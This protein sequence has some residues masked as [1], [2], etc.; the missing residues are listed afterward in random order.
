MVVAT[1]VL[2]SCQPTETVQIQLPLKTSEFGLA[3]ESDFLLIRYEDLLA[4]PRSELESVCQFLEID[5]DSAMLTPNSVAEN[6]GDTRGRRNIVTDNT[7]KYRRRMNDNTRLRIE[8][9]AGEQLRSMGYPVDFSGPTKR[10][11]P[12][13]LKGYQLLDGI[14][15]VRFEVAQRGVIEALRLRWNLFNTSGN[16]SWY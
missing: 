15:L 5:F 12:L 11:S 8:A 3:N 13:S 4:D 9:I 10:L 7:E 6:L 16:R 14:N 2:T 1:A